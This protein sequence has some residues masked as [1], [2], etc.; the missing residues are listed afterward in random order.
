MD[1]Y[2]W[3]I[4]DYFYLFSERKF[5]FEGSGSKDGDSLI[6]DIALCPG[7]KVQTVLKKINF[8]SEKHSIQ[9]TLGHK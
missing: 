5:I 1:D 2:L 3:P 4:K 7:D 9:M 6:E 8:L